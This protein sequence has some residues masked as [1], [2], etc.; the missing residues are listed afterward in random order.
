MDTTLRYVVL[1]TAVL[2]LYCMG[3]TFHRLY[4][5]PIATFPGPKLAATTHWYQRYFDLVARGTGGQF[6]LEIKRLH[7]KYGPIV[8][9]T[10]DE[11]HID[12][13][14][15]WHEVYCNSTTAKPIDKQAKLRYR[16]GVPDAIFSTPY[17]E[18]HRQRRQAMAPFFSKQRL[19][20]GNDRVSSLTER[21]SQRLSTEYAGTGRVLNVG[22]MFSGMAIDVV[23]DLAFNRSTNCLEAPDFKAPLLGATASTLWA[24][25]W[26]AHFRFLRHS[27]DWLPDGILGALLPLFKPILELR[28][29]ISQQANQ[30]LSNLEKGPSD[31][32]EFDAKTAHRT[33]F[34]DILASNLPPQELSFKRLTQEAFAITSAGMETTKSTLTLAVFHVLDQPAVQG[35]LKA[36]LAEAMPDPNVILPWIELE[37]L[38]YLTAIIYESE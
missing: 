29:G 11:L 17:A 19:R 21:I 13:P 6:V 15:Y 24:C 34:N 22:D 37:K 35:R 36:E 32:E 14:D 28:T 27:M 38:P 25:H 8:R 7:E 9:I 33:I 16:F 1:L 31:V 5:S 2:V 18:Q 20:E 12:D 10:P 26:N 3:L 30:I 23:T 4:L